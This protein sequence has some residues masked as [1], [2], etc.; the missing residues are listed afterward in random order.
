MNSVGR[1]C[2]VTAH[3]ARLYSLQALNQ[4][5]QGAYADD[6][7]LRYGSQDQFSLFSQLVGPLVATIGLRPA[8]FLLYLVFNTLFVYAL[9]RLVRTLIADTVI[10][11]LALVYL[12]TASLRYGGHDI[13]T[14]H[15]QFVTPR[16]VA[17]PFTLLALEQMLRRRFLP[18]LGFL[19]GG[20]LV[21]QLMAF[22]GVMI[23]IGYV[24]I[25]FLPTTLFWGLVVAGSVGA[26]SILSIPSIAIPIFGEMNDHWHQIIRRSVGYNYPDTWHVNNWLNLAVSF[27]MPIAACFTLNRDD[28]DR[29]RFLL[30]VV[31]A[32][33]LGFLTTFAASYLPYA[34]LFQGQPYRVLWILKVLQIPLGFI[35]IARLGASPMPMA[36]FAAVA[37]L[38]FFCV[39]HYLPSEFLILGVVLSIALF[40]SR[41][42]DAAG[43]SWRAA[44][45]GLI[46]SALAWMA[47]RCWCFVTQ[48]DVIMNQFDMSEW[49]LFELVSPIF[50][51]VAF[52]FGITLCQSSARN[53]EWA[54]WPALA[55]AVLAPVAVFAFEATPTLRE[56]HTRLGADMAFLRD[57]V[58]ER[59]HSRPPTIYCPMGR[60][61]LMWIDVGATSYFDIIQTAGVMFNQRTGDEIERRC[62]VVAKF[63]MDR[64]R[65]E[66]A[67]LDDARR[68]GVEDLFKISLNSA[69]PTVD[70]L[71]RLC[72]EPGLD[73]VVLPLEFAG[74][75][76][77]TNGRLFVYECY[78][79]SRLRL[80]VHADV[81]EHAA[82]RRER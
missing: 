22:G 65:R 57:F 29:R 68:L 78:Q 54:K 34:L 37:L 15:E 16:I 73:Y 82:L 44:V 10:S 74:V 20:A 46:V 55:I 76:S 30:V 32:G 48:R 13:F 33:A 53:I 1:P 42:N 4:A 47:Y 81:P 40:M 60:P 7:F 31:L 56:Q 17:V 49:V 36:R 64:Q 77:G 75:Y 80:S 25:T 9:F 39:Q 69:P 26:V 3:D 50:C 58:K 63:E 43:A 12:C 45:C 14:V 66:S 19:I 51:I 79:C 67:F 70:E 18:A 35:L 38:A 5:E 62:G 27:A 41:F 52:T 24:A 71:A 28:P 21:H 23:W 59:G 8:F 6:V 72:Q 61:D 2:S 11:T